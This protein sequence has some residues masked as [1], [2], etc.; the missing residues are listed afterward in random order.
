MKTF[1]QLR[2]ELDE[3]DYG[4]AWERVKSGASQIGAG[5]VEA[6]RTFVKRDLPVLVKKGEEAYTKTVKPT[7]K[8]AAG[9]VGSALET[10]GKELRQMSNEMFDPTQND[11][12]EKI[13]SQ[14]NLL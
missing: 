14:K 10:G 12:G 13:S 3:A 8:K 6:G 11:A 5:A 4:S 2:N 7:V 1:K 9:A